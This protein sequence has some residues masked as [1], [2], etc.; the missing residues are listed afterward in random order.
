MRVAAGRYRAFAPNNLMNAAAN[1]DGRHYN[2]K[3]T[4][5]GAM[6]RPL[7]VLCKDPCGIL[8]GPATHAHIGQPHI[9]FR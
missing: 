2:A 8:P 3:K 1:G 9:P 7:S 6:L 5:P 4:D